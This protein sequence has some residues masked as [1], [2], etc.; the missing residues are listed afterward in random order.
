MESYETSWAGSGEEPGILQRHDQGCVERLR[1]IDYPNLPLSDPTGEQ[2][3]PTSPKLVEGVFSEV[4]IHEAVLV[5]T[6]RAG[7]PTQSW[8]ISSLT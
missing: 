5:L 6:P 2:L 7:Y 3:A 8:A 4:H 1:G